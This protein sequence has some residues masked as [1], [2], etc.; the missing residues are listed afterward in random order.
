MKHF[1]YLIITC[2]LWCLVGGFFGVVLA[3]KDDGDI[4]I[5]CSAWGSWKCYDSQ[6]KPM[7]VLN[8]LVQNED[9]IGTELD[10]V[11]RSQWWFGVAYLKSSDTFDSVRQNIDV[12]LQW[13]AFLGLT[14]AVIFV[15]YNGLRLMFTPMS[16]EQAGIVKK[17]IIYIS[18]GVVLITGFY[19]ILK[20]FLSIFIDIV[21]R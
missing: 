17:R 2:L 16:P 4:A 15:I 5:D 18:L 12:Y 6:S 3:A 8:D 20:I 9:Q 11:E 19:F 7:D 10:A 13:I 14:F 21:V 1:V